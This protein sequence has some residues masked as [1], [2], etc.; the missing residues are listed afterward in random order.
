MQFLRSLLK[1][2]AQE[3]EIPSLLEASAASTTG[4]DMTAYAG[5]ALCI[6]H[7]AAGTGGAN[8][9]LDVKVQHCAT[10]DGSY[11]DISGATFEQIDDTAG[12]SI[13]GICIDLDPLNPF[14]K[15]YFTIAGTTPDFTLSA[16][17]VAFP[18]GS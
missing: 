18:K 16:S 12:G 14:V 10:I 9:T 13:Q 5:S 3:I 6:I 4:V 11:A 7:S 15:F 2:V 8:E 17:I 1:A